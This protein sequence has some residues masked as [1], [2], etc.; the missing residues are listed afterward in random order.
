MALRELK[1]TW[2][3][4]PGEWRARDRI[5][6]PKVV[7]LE[8]NRAGFLCTCKGILGASGKFSESVRSAFQG[9]WELSPNT[10]PSKWFYCPGLNSGN[11]FR[12]KTN[13]LMPD[14]QLRRRSKSWMWCPCVRFNVPTANRLWRPTGFSLWSQY[15][16]VRSMIYSGNI[17]WVST[18]CQASFL[19]AGDAKEIRHVL[20]QFCEMDKQI[21]N[22][23]Q[24]D[25]MST[26]TEGWR[27]G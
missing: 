2:K 23:P 13:S 19:V 10:S 8:S 17:C 26:G 16:L 4:R 25:V 20:V 24:C 7:C 11:P 1:A 3:W 22:E 5:F 15:E 6:D 14:G 18:K 9:A 21:H 27:A 12:A